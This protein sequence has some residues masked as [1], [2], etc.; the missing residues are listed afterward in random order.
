MSLKSV[1]KGKLQRGE[2][3]TCIF[4][5]CKNCKLR[6]Q[7]HLV[8]KAC[9]MGWTGTLEAKCEYCI[10]LNGRCASAE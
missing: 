3:K 1:L 5:Y 7:L 8:N 4:Y 10:G 2:G 6:V 9:K